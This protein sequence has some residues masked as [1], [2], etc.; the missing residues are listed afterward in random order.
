MPVASHRIVY[1]RISD[2]RPLC[3]RAGAPTPVMNGAHCSN[4]WQVKRSQ[5]LHCR[6]TRHQRNSSSNP[7]RR[8][9]TSVT[10]CEISAPATIGE[11]SPHQPLWTVSPARSR[12]ARDKAVAGWSWGNRPLLPRSAV[13]SS[14]G[15]AARG[16]PAPNGRCTLSGATM[17]W[18]ANLQ[19]PALICSIAFAI[20]SFMV[21]RI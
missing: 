12:R 5:W 17:K 2:Q 15:Q 19:L 6:I 14:R 10:F 7:H 1:P 20:S 3:E 9:S 18:M 16:R 13:P 4:H 21:R 11:G 8:N